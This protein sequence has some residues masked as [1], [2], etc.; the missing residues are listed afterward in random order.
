[1]GYRTLLSEVSV[2]RIGKLP[3]IMTEG[4]RCG[5]FCER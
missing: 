5:Q 3:P 1:M 4:G 2:D